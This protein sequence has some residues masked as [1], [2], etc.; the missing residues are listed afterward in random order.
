MR[1]LVSLALASAALTPVALPAT[2]QE[3]PIGT[4]RAERV[5]FTCAGPIKLQNVPL[6]QSEFP[7]WSTTAPGSAA[8]GNGCG[9]YENSQTAQGLNFEAK[10]TFAG[11][12]DNITVELY[13]VYTSDGRQGNVLRMRV[14]LIIDDEELIYSEPLMIPTVPSG[15]TG[16]AHKVTYTLTGLNYEDEPGDGTRV[17]QI[18][19]FA[20]SSGDDVHSFWL[21]GASE[22]PGGLTFNPATPESFKIEIN[23]GS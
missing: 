19:V 3:G 7:G 17:H 1:K 13:N 21:W 9:M 23:R 12:L 16:A 14:Q 20:R 11:N 5:Y 6:L 10:G 22:V 8:L 15:S 4:L 2:A 18:H